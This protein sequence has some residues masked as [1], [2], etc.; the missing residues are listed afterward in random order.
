M[1]HFYMRVSGHVFFYNFLQFTI[2]TPTRLPIQDC[3]FANIPKINLNFKN[4]SEMNK[5]IKIFK[6]NLTDALGLRCSKEYL[7]Y[8][9]MFL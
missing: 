2:M 4:W 8:Y 1:L 5:N 6:Y 3:H 9:T 7:K